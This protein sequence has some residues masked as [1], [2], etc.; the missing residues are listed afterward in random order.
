MRAKGETGTMMV[1]SG[2]GVKGSVNKLMTRGWR[3]E[4]RRERERCYNCRTEVLEKKVRGG[5]RSREDGFR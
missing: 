2:A 1:Y 5:D 3:W 4:G